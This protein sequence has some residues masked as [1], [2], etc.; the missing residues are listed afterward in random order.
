LPVTENMV[1]LRVFVSDD[2]PM[3]VIVL[4]MEGAP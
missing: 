3:D 2:K 1:R 4:G